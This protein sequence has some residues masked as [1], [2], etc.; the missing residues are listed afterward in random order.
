MVPY[1]SKLPMNVIH[2]L[3]EHSGSST[4]YFNTWTTVEPDDQ[5]LQMTPFWW[6][7]A[8]LD[9]VL[10]AMPGDNQ[11]VIAVLRFFKDGFICVS[12]TKA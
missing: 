6:V 9:G 7:Y 2:M 11:T 8:A 4:F 3:A 1:S 5:L 12:V 10:A